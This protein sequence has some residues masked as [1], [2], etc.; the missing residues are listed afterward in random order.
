MFTEVGNGIID[1]KNIFKHANKAGMKYFFVE[2]DVC[3]GN[4][5]DS[6]TQKHYLYKKESSLK[7]FI[8]Q[9]T[10][11]GSSIGAPGFFMK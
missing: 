10:Q 1:F 3:P 8:N 2:Q 4:P 11:A 9:S 6:I 7:I 5:Y